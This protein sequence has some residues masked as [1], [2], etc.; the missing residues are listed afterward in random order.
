MKN[1]EV[2][3]DKVLVS[4]S[5]KQIQLEKQGCVFRGQERLSNHEIDVKKEC[6]CGRPNNEHI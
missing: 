6:Y 1:E 2:R 3:G 4:K 5:K